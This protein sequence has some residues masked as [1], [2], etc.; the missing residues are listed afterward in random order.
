MTFTLLDLFCGAGGAAVGYHLEW[1]TQRE[2][3]QAVPPAYTEFIGRQ[4]L[5]NLYNKKEQEYECVF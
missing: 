3:T 4:L 1:M 5:S 2:L